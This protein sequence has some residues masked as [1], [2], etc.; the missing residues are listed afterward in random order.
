MSGRGHIR[1]R[2]TRSWELKFDLDTDPLTGAR[3]TRYHSF[4]GTKREAEAELVRLKASADRGDYVAASKTTL[5]QF[6]DRWET[7]A[8][9]QVS[10]KTLERYRELALHHVRPHLGA[11]QL[12]KLRTVNFV[13]LYGRLQRAKPGGAGLAPRTVGH[14][15]R[16]LHR[17]FSDATKWGIVA[18]NPVAMADPPRVQPTEITILTAEQ[19]KIVLDALRGRPL[20]PVAVVALATGIRRGELV[21]LRWHDVDLDGGLIRIER[22]LEQ[23]NAGLAFKPPKTKAGRRTVTIPPAITAELRS[24]WCI[25]QEHR[26]ALGVGRAGPDDLVFARPDTAPWPPDSLT[27]AWQKAVVS[28]KLPQVTLHALRHTHVSQLIAAGLDVVTVSR[29]IGHSNPTVTLNVYAH[30]FGNTDQRAATVVETAL[31][32]I[33]GA[34]MPG[35]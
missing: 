9:A 12:Q 33:L 24:H 27:T 19:I 28:L 13:E 31:A 4:K 20:Y 1:R 26:L 18:S 3:I 6:I 10:A 29:R 35:E 34:A 17:L 11:A 8:E 23:T 2:G 7:W 21:G 15:H 16:L 5:S 22:S 32:G 25:Q 14:V 30:L